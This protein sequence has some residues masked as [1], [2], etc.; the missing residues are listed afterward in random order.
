MS[1]AER[2]R[3]M[4]RRRAEER[5]KVWAPFWEA[6]NGSG[7][8]DAGQAPDKRPKNSAGLRHLP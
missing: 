4:S 2:M 6:V 7:Q 5:W 3:N 8:D 1:A